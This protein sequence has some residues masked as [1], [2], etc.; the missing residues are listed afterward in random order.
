M[1]HCLSLFD[2][3]LDHTRVITRLLLGQFKLIIII[4]DCITHY[5]D[6]IMEAKSQF[7]GKNELISIWEVVKEGGSKLTFEMNLSFLSF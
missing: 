5:Y 3:S 4:K 2:V 1:F 6:S 7:R